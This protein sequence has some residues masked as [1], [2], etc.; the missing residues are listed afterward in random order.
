MPP[1]P[2][3][4]CFQ[5]SWGFPRDSLFKRILALGFFQ[6]SPADINRQDA[7]DWWEG[8]ASPVIETQ[9]L[10]E[11][12]PLSRDLHKCFSAFYSPSRVRQGGLCFLTFAKSLVKQFSL[13]EA[14]FESGGALW[15]YF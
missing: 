9:S 5:L 2:L 1:V 11:M 15:V 4:L 8:A 12:M 13:R 10:G 3:F 14:L 6:L 7:M